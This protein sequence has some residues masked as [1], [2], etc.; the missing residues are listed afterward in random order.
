MRFSVHDGDEIQPA[1]EQMSTNGSC[2][3]ASECPQLLKGLH[4]TFPA[5]TGDGL[6][7]FLG[8]LCIEMPLD[9]AMRIQ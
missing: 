2:A 7:R 9:F 1:P 4:A 8:A 5:K 6:F 3:G